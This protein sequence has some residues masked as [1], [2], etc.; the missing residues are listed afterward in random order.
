MKSI[1]NTHLEERAKTGDTK[2]AIIVAGDSL[3]LI[4]SSLDLKE[5]FLKLS[6]ISDVVLACRVSP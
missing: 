5:I 3:A 6:D 2:T 1:L 4:D